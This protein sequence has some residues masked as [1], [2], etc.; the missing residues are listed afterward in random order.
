MVSRRNLLKM[1]AGVGAAPLLAHQV[2]CPAH[3]TTAQDT[4]PV[5]I[6][7]NTE[8]NDVRLCV[9]GT[10][11]ENGQPCHLGPDGSSLVQLAMPDKD[12]TVVK[13]FSIK[14]AESGGSSTITLPRMGAGRMW[15]AVDS[16]LVFEVNRGGAGP[17][18][19]FPSVSNHTDA[20]YR[21]VWDFM[22]FTLDGGG[23]H[24]NVTHV[25][26]VAIPISIDLDTR[27]SGRQS[28]AGL[29]PGGLD[30]VCD[31]LLIQDGF[32]KL[33]I[34]DGARRLRAV[35]PA[36]G[37]KFPQPIFDSR[38]FDD[39]IDQVW[40]RYGREDLIVDTQ[41]QWGVSKGRV[42]NGRL[43][44]AG[45]ADGAFDKPST[46]D[47]LACAGS[48]TRGN[49]H[50]GAIAA[51]LGAAFNRST[52]AAN[53][54]QP[55]TTTSGFYRHRITNH[56]SRILHAAAKDKLAYGFPF[57]DVG[58]GGGCASFVSSATP[59]KLTITL[60]RLHRG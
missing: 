19:V 33:V 28:S 55:D 25:D 12:R 31:A 14:L 59:T 44:F 8:Y 43:T 52:L 47:V 46:W 5:T 1:A 49:N 56:Y 48:L 39:Y 6:I 15:F 24:A 3:A 27:S 45:V 30:A 16:P 54:H 17:A 9:T 10:R 38:Y 26:S 60:N 23:M 53:P 2:S 13:D 41:T 21:T 7:N 32:D 58:P 40:D 50:A 20:N 36:A 4:L 37:I 57:D 42:H 29:P 35:S 18:F 11:L 34:T 51:R 22:E